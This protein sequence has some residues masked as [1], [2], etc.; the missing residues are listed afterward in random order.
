MRWL[1]LDD[2]VRYS[3]LLQPGEQLAMY[4]PTVRCH[5]EQQ[6][7]QQQ[8]NEAVQGPQLIVECADS[9][10]LLVQADDG[11]SSQA[12]GAEHRSSPTIEQQQHQ[13]QQLSWYDSPASLSIGQQHVVLCGV[14]SQ[15]QRLANRPGC[16]VLLS[17]RLADSPAGAAVGSSVQLHLQFL[18]QTSSKV[19]GLARLSAFADSLVQA[20]VS[21]RLCACPL[22]HVS[23]WDAAV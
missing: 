1:L 18:P 9:V 11:C 16:G 7:Q 6:Q 4:C 10:L 14:V 20:Q 23:R 15:L 5:L 3:H 2:A 21:M 8:Q 22:G 17:C 13:Q 12:A 19:G